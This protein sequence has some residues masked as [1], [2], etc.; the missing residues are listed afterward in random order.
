MEYATVVVDGD[1]STEYYI[2]YGVESDL[3][4]CSIRVELPTFVCDNT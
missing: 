1:L 3:D 2:M 4:I